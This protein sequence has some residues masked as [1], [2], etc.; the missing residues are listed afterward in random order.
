ML[1]IDNYNT[2]YF[3]SDAHLGEPNSTN[4]DERKQKLFTF[5]DAIAEPGNHLF[6]VGDLFDFW[7][8]WRKVIPKRHFQVLRKFAEWNDRGLKL[9]YLAG[10]HDFRLGGFLSDEVG[11]HT[12]ENHLDF[13]ADCKKFHLFHGDGVKKTDYGYRFL[14]KV[15]RNRLNQW[16]FLAIHPDWGMKLADISSKTSRDSQVDRNPYAD[17]SDYYEYAQM[18]INEGYDYIVM[19]HTHIPLIKELK[20]GYYLNSGNWYKKFTFGSYKSGEIKIHTFG[21]DQT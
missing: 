8:E 11:F 3:L 1:K 16:L 17:A 6:I 12:A 9:Y 18:K 20:G 13:E 10:N 2:I 21:G 5:G 4:D 15:L 7:F 19:G 14:K